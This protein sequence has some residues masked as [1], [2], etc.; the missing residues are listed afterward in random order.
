MMSTISKPMDVFC[1][2]LS[3]VRVFN[4]CNIVEVVQGRGVLQR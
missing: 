4:F 1:N 3:N 2:V